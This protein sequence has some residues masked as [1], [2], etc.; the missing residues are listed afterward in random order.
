MGF[1]SS[2]VVSNSKHCM[3]AS[4]IRPK[5]S[6]WIYMLPSLS[7]AIYSKIH[8]QEELRDKSNSV[9]DAALGNEGLL[10]RVYN[11]G[12]LQPSHL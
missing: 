9:T 5:A 6:R 12:T 10:E 3:T 7:V 8:A 2:F 1:V 4:L 11:S